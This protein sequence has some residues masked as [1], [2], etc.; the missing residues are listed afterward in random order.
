M[1]P[2][3]DPLLGAKATPSMKA[4]RKYFFAVIGLMLL[5]IGMGV[6]TAHYAVEGQSFF[7]L[8]LAQILP[9]TISRTVHWLSTIARRRCWPSFSSSRSL[10][11]MPW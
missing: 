8:P 4:T 3:A 2:K 10:K 9:Y 7:G 5:Q 1:V 11:A 6:I